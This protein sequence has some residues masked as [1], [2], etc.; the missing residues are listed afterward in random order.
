MQVGRNS[1]KYKD[2]YIKVLLLVLQ[3]FQLS[4]V[5]IPFSFV[6]PGFEYFLVYGNTYLPLFWCASSF[7][8]IPCL[9][10][11]H[12]LEFVRGEG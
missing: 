11:L 8:S 5:K 12:V 10:F 2:L 4:Y 3:L 1:H 7:P 9:L 6:L